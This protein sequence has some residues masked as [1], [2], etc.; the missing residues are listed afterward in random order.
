MSEDP[1]VN[2]HDKIVELASIRTAICYT[3]GSA[4]PNPGPSG[5]GASIFLRNPDRVHDLGVSTGSGTN[6]IGEL[7]ALHICF[8]HLTSLFER[9]LF[10]QAIIFSDS[11][12]ALGLASSSKP[13]A[14]NHQIVTALRKSHSDAR[15]K[16]KVDLHWIRGHSNIGGNERADRLS[17][18]FS[19]FN[20]SPPPPFTVSRCA[21]SSYDSDWW[22]GFPLVG[23]PCDHYIKTI[24]HITPVAA[25]SDIT[26]TPTLGSDVDSVGNESGQRRSARIRARTRP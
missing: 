23:L 9:G 24:P 8:M 15:S 19:S 13:P 7:V 25:P 16:F 18:I 1:S 3:D 10:D 6:N 11:R 21:Y 20:P 14:S 2:K 5:A 22:P 12:Y 4:T 17:N 26:P